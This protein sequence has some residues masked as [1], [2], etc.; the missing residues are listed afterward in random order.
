M[1]DKIALKNSTFTDDVRMDRIVQFDERSRSF[2][3]RELV[4][5]K[6]LRSYTWRCN[7]NFDQGNDGACVAYSLAHELVARPAEVTG[8]TDKWMVENVYWEAQ[9]NDPWEGG[10]YPGANPFYHGTSILAGVKVLHKK[11]FFSEYRWGFGLNDVLNGV[12]HNGP[13]V[14]GVNWYEGMLYPDKS[15]MIRPTG[16]IVGGHAVLLRSV[17]VRRSRVTIRNSWGEWWGKNGD[18]YLSFED[19]GRLL[20]EQGEAVFLVKRTAKNYKAS[21]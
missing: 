5:S 18:A 4:G 1:P 13:A 12:G 7:A 14:I 16:P 6:P 21:F 20:R 11:G 15:G 10:S 3:I 8:I 17:D 9:R 19:L 2:G